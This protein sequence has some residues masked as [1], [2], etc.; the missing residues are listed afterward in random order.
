MSPCTGIL[1]IE[2][3]AVVTRYVPVWVRPWWSSPPQLDR[4]DEGEEGEQQE[5]HW[6]D[7]GGQLDRGG[8]GEDGEEEQEQ[9][10][11]GE[12]HPA[13]EFKPGEGKNF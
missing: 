1:N 9:E 3:P 10:G 4:G 13:G 12:G 7:R 11:R 6:G 8:E 2:I 5:F